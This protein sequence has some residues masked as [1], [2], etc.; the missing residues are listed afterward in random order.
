MCTLLLQ[1][2]LALKK[3]KT[4]KKKDLLALEVTNY[5]SYA[6]LWRIMDCFKVT[7]FFPELRRSSEKRCHIECS[8]VEVDWRKGLYFACGSNECKL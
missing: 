3:R 6:L 4:K 5:S 1:I 7:F 2:L 8:T